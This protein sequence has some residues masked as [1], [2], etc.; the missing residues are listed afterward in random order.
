MSD[1]IVF[2]P[3]VELDTSENLRGFIDSCRTKLTVF[4]PGLNFEG[5]V[6]DITESLGLKGH[7]NKRHRLV[8]STLATVNDAR[9]VALGEPFLSFSKA[10]IRY[11][12]GLRPTKNVAFRLAALRALEAALTENGGTPDPTKTDL[13]VLNRAGQ[14]LAEKYEA[15]TAY[16]I[17]GQLELLATFLSENALTV[18]P[19]RWR[20]FLKRPG[21]AVRVG[22]EFDRRREDKMP[23]SAALEALPKVFRLAKDPG[24]VLFSSVA[25]LLCAAPDR[26]NEVLLLPEQCEVWQKSRPDAE[27]SYGLRWWPAKGAEPMV[28]WI[29]PSMISVVQ[30]AV[31]RI[32]AITSNARQIAKWYEDNPSK[33]YL[34]E[35]NQHLR[36]KEWLTMTELREVVGLGTRRTTPLQWCR[37]FDVP[38]AI[39]GR[40][41]HV[42]FSDVE[43]TVLARLPIGFPVLDRT[44]G[45]KYSEALFSVRVNEMNPQKNPYRCLIETVTIN[46]INSGLGGRAEHGFSSIFT[47]FGFVEP[48]GDPIK[49]TTHQFRHYLNTLAQAG[50]MSQL[51]IAKWSGRKDVRQNAAYDHVTPDQML[52]KIRDAVGDESQMFGPLAEIP[53]K[54]LIPRDEFARLRIPTAHTTNLGFCVHDYTMSPCQL[55]RDCIHCEDLV[56]VKGDEEKTMRLRQ[57][58]DEARDLLRKAEDAVT[59]GYAG[60]D[61]W[62]E[63]HLSAVERLSQLCSIMDDPKVPHGAVV[64]L[65]P[66]RGVNRVGDSSRI[67][68]PP[69][70]PMN[71]PAGLLAEILESMGG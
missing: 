45:T 62:L 35:N 29:V 41:A 10:F 32:R 48:D 47:R 7:G 13:F 21:D 14:L 38:T 46:Q 28:K 34:D 70:Q 56:C 20:N 39:F 69:T 44:T 66:P 8:F 49:I 2:R 53:K 63:H 33:L 65:A 25:A 15:A 16:R 50:G 58:L 19:V 67:A 24:D 3:K 36:S 60:G 27:E 1:V 12:Q 55:H 59:D 61:R 18:V 22:K 54:V 11:M 6:W 17:G 5:N 23:S 71:P 43:R 30:D 31:S 37:T 42:R 57:N 4:G 9:T 52:Q 64:Q 51:D 40:Q 68:L 26:I